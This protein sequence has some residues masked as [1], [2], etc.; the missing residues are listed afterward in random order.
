[1]GLFGK[2]KSPEI[3]EVPVRVTNHHTCRAGYSDGY[4]KG[5]DKG[6]ESHRNL[7]GIS[8]GNAKYTS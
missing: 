5:Y 7:D 1:M 2:R 4:D 3:V 6:R 8:H